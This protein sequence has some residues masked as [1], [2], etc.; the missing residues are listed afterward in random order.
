MPKGN[1]ATAYVQI[2]PSAEGIK[3]NLANVLDGEATS[4]GK[5]AGGKLASA[6]GTAAKVGVAAIGAATTAVAGFAKASVDA[7]MSFDSSMSQVAATMGFSTEELNT[8]GSKA[9]ETYK[10][11]S[12]FAQEMGSTTAF[13][14]SEAADALNYMALAGYDAETS[15][16]MLPNVLNLAA[17]GGIEL[18]QASDMVTDAQSALGLSLEETSRMVDQMAMASS[19][20]NTSVGQLGE[21]F[22]TIGATARNLSGGTQ[23][24]AT[25][26]GVLADNGTKGADG[27]I[28]LRNILAGLS[29]TTSD[30][31]EAMKKYT[32]GL[33]DAEGNMR[34]VADV[35]GEL[36]TSLEAMSDKEKEDVIHTIFN[37]ADWADAESMIFT[38]TER[39]NELS[40]SI[41][42]AKGSAQNMAE[43][44]LDN[45]AGDITLF[46]S[47]L[48][49]AKIAIA[50][51]LTPS[52]REFVQFGSDGLSRLTVAFKEGGLSG[53]MS[54][55]GTILSEGLAQITTMLPSFIE[56]GMQLLSA[57]GQ[58]IVDNI[59]VLIDSVLEIFNMLVNYL[60]EN[61]GAVIEAGLQIIVQLATGIAQALPTLI[62]SIVQVVLTIVEYLVENIDLLIDAAIQLI[63]G[64]ADGL[65]EAIPIL[66]EKAPIIVGKLVLGL[67]KAA[68]K[69]AE[70]ALRLIISL[71]NGLVSFWGKLLEVIPGLME[72]VKNKFE[73]FVSNFKEIG[74]NIVSGIWEGIKGAWGNLVENA[75]NLAK[76]LYTAVHDF[77]V[78][79]SPS[80]LFE[81]EIGRWLPAGIA[82]G[83]EDNA[84]M[85]DDA[86]MEIGEHT[87]SIGEDIASNS[88]K[89]ELNTDNT[90]NQNAMYDLLQRYLPDI[91]EG[92]NV[93]VSLQGDAGGIFK[94]VRQQNRQFMKQT[95]QSAFA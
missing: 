83:I 5:S 46:Q 8:A 54:E 69:L 9:A 78:I 64:L 26:L 38:A 32:N 92:G 67:I 56:A 22:L 70:A 62:P 50:D 88:Y 63:V 20:S 57:L 75:T 3:G 80:K 71:A 6:L 18:A 76:D 44:Q 29:G 34:P 59:P 14:A 17:A 12:D 74:S 53:A 48:E 15:M 91:A 1:V 42:D 51:Q 45:L 28:K 33:Y 21:A 47:A 2:V 4:A 60:L 41:G 25:L 31:A 11:L 72:K 35:L 16:K 77:F 95:G 61:A 40:E 84:Y 36:R 65:M 27:G 55:F 93:N 39:Y 89:G 94:A 90:T 24:L 81:K 37:K 82:V 43:V 49:G 66:V 79:G 85:V 10:K 73:Y 58:G 87:L 23:E 86:M 19:K 13:S 30:G 68:P 7:G 52:L